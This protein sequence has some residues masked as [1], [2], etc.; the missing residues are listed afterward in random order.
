M[1]EIS[2]KELQEISE[3]ISTIL[4]QNSIDTKIASFDGLRSRLKL[5]F[6]KLYQMTCDG[7]ILYPQKTP[8]FFYQDYLLITD[9]VLPK[10]VVQ[11]IVTAPLMF[12]D[13]YIEISENKR[14]YLL[15]VVIE[16]EIERLQLQKRKKWKGKTHEVLVPILISKEQ[17]EEIVSIFQKYELCDDLS[18]YALINIVANYN[19]SSIYLKKQKKKVCSLLREL[20]MLLGDEWG[21][22]AVLYTTN[23]EKTL[24]VVKKNYYPF[25]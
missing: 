1:N 21:N 11:R 10:Y 12:D 20:T 15:A 2:D 13:T 7:E 17:E 19:L 25:S 8:C 6:G 22:R 3:I 18:C 24:D 9:A 4:K 23:G 14:S 5:D 16:N